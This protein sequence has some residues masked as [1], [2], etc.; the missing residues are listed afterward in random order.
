M[1]GQSIYALVDL[2]GFESARFMSTSTFGRCGIHIER[3]WDRAKITN[4]NETAAVLLREG[5]PI[6]LET[7]NPRLK[8]EGLKVLHVGN[9]Y[10]VLNKRKLLRTKGISYIDPRSDKIRG[11]FREEQIP[12][13]GLDLKPGNLFVGLTRETV[14]MRKGQHAHVF[15]YDPQVLKHLSSMFI[16]PGFNGRLAIEHLVTEKV[17]VKPGDEIALLQP[18]ETG[19]VHAYQGKY[20]N[21]KSA[22]P[23]PHLR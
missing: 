22:R 2:R 21:Q 18:F 7:G 6:R 3:K 10:L 14:K 12:E 8:K 15:S 4:R 17:I 11:F 13:N 1:P 5:D 9:K 19:V 16:H 23:K 20:Q